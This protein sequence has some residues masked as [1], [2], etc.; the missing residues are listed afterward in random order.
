M[1]TLAYRAHLK[2]TKKIKRCEYGTS[3]HIH[4]AEFPSELTNGHDKLVFPTIGWKG[5]SGT[6][7]LAYWAHSK[8][9][10]KMKC[11]EYGT[12]VHIHK[13]SFSSQLTNG[14]DK[15]AFPNN[16]L[17]RLAKNGHSS[18]SGPF[19]SYIEN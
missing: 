17:E 13:A 18:L 1:N 3:V 4:N 12:R 6:N 2:V 9:T 14:S 16:G 19:K 7:T 5:L 10:K 11:C 15:L 8:V